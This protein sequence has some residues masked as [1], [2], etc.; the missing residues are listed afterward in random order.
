[1]YVYMK[2]IK[3]SLVSASVF[4]FLV[5]LFSIIPKSAFAAGEFITTWKTD[6]PGTSNSTSITIPTT[7]AGYNYDVDWDNDGNPDETGITGN[8]THDFGATGTYTIRITGTFPRIYFN[9]GG[10]RQKI[11]SVDQWGTISWTS[12]TGAFSGCNNLTITASDSPDM[13]LV[14]N[15]TQA[16]KDATSLNQNLGSWNMSQVISTV[17]MFRGATS[18]NQDL[19]GWDTGSLVSASQMFY[20]ATAFNQP[21]GSWDMSNVIST[22]EMF[23]GATSFNQP[24][25]SWDM[26]SV[27]NI[28]QMFFNASSFNQDIGLWNTGMVTAMNQMFSGATVFNQNI[29]AW[30][31]AD[32]TNFYGMFTSAA[33]F[34]QDIGGWDTGSATNMG[35]MFLGAS[36]FNQNISNWDVADVTDF[37]SMFQGATA[38]NQPI[39]S[40]DI[41]STTNISGMFSS[42]SFN[43]DISL[44]DTS[45]VVYMNTMFFNTPFNQDI[46]SWNTG[47]VLYFN[48][49]FWNATL[50][51]QDIGSW[52]VASAIGM[53]NMFNGIILS[54]QNYDAILA[55]WSAQLVQP[56]LVFGGGNSKYCDQVSRDLLT[57]L[58]NSWIITDGGLDNCHTLTYAAGTGGS[59]SGEVLQSVLDTM[60]GTAV[61]AI[62][63]AGYT[64]LKWSDDIIDNPRTD[65]NVTGDITVT[66]LFKKLGGGTQI[67]GHVSSMP[68]QPKKEPKDILGSGLC[69]ANLII[70]D[71]MKK[72]DRNGNYSEYNKNTI[73]E[74]NILQAHTNRI[75][76]AKYT[77]A[78][79]PVDGIFG[80]LTKQGVQ[81]LQT[82]L[83]DDLKL[84]LGP[85]GTDGIVGPFT[86]EAINHSC[87]GM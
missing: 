42:T 80:A 75:L 83:R 46:S 36:S 81:R 48:N 30:D 2:F 52:N 7:G 44:W 76:A 69:P 34:N 50:F 20:G 68:S 54:T 63:N 8:V 24:I 86:R 25:G 47:N 51:D 59:L 85:S 32:V 70:H 66:G 62:P 74:V 65:T 41:G 55:G 10:D 84:N 37:G 22:S 5:G 29:G 38:F 53:D 58:P 12:M 3:K 14:T 72:G 21:I 49:M 73:K 18:F 6:N 82:V 13:S 39:G 1:M 64:F 87:G 16:F 19:S 61:T 28:Y 57:N 15:T 60:D 17:A 79:G 33:S 23:R 27:V 77:Q 43:Q 56:S 26:S 31:V 67:S 78:S 40:W 45:N 9:G 71:S 4:L 11:L 35:V